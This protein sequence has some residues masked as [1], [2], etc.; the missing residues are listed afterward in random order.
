[1]RGGKNMPA[2]V[3]F[4]N[5]RPKKLCYTAPSLSHSLSFSWFPFFFSRFPVVAT[6]RRFPRRVVNIHESRAPVAVVILPV[7]MR[8]SCCTEIRKATSGT[9]TGTKGRNLRRVSGFVGRL[10]ET[11]R[12]RLKPLCFISMASRTG[13]V[14][15]VPIVAVNHE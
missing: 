12:R 7:V 9:A 8:P 1:M 2:A 4:L 10:T 5:E 11:F 15:L 14:R 6:S 3:A 13:K